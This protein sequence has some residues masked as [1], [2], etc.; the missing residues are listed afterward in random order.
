M[1]KTTALQGIGSRRIIHG[2]TQEAK[3][4][5]QIT[6]TTGT[7]RRESQVGAGSSSRG[8][9][10]NSLGIRTKESGTADSRKAAT[11]NRWRYQSAAT[12]V[13]I[14]S[15]LSDVQDPFVGDA[16]KT[17][18]AFDA[19]LSQDVPAHRHHRKSQEEAPCTCRTSFR[20]TTLDS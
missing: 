17:I 10:K 7:S 11:Q 2:Q 9:G 5:T 3:T 14:V 18:A 6:K 13:P 4:K 19:A 16:G 20:R 12:F 8:A 1:C 15:R